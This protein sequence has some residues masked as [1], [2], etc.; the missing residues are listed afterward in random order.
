MRCPFCGE[1]DTKVIDSRSIE[2]RKKRRRMC[3]RCGKRFTTYETVERPLLMVAKRDGSFEPFDRNKLLKGIFSSLKKRPVDVETVNNLVDE[4][5][6][7]L[8]NEMV[9]T[10]SPDRIGS[11][12]LER[13]RGIDTVAYVR[14]ASVYQAFSD[15]EDFVR[16]I[17]EVQEVRQ[18]NDLTEPSA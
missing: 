3:Q 4:I 2:G 1:E 17:S 5:E 6:A 8:A 15:I 11:M 10:V 16:I 12:V 9:S 18:Q 14:F 13:L 7:E